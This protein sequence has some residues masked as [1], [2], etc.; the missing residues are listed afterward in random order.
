MVAGQHDALLI[1]QEDA[2]DRV[3]EQAVE[4]RGVLRDHH[5][6]LRHVTAAHTGRKIEAGVF[7]RLADGVLRALAAGVLQGLHVVAATAVVD[8]DGAVGLVERAVGQHRAIGRVQQDAAD[9]QFL[10]LLLQ[11]LVEPPPCGVLHRLLAQA[12]GIVQDDRGV[13]PV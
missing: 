10:D 6:A 9:A 2:A 7:Q 4:G 5:H 11:L 3:V 8:A 13:Q 1:G 12:L